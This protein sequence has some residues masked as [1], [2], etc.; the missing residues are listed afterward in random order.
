MQTYK[1]IEEIEHKYIWMDRWVVKFEYG[2]GVLV[3]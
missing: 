2:G 1:Q 3:I